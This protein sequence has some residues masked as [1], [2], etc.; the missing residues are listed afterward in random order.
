MKKTVAIIGYTGFVGSY[1][2]NH[3]QNEFENVYLFNSKNFQNINIK[4]I[5]YDIIYCCGISAKKWLANQNP[6]QDW[7]NMNQLLEVLKQTSCSKFIHIS[8]IDVY[9][10]KYLG[11]DENTIP[12]YLSSSEH[13]PYGIHRLHF[14]LELKKIYNENL[15]IVRLPALFGFGLRKNVL[16]D[17]ITNQI[18]KHDINSHDCLQW[19]NIEW[20]WED[21][22]FIEQ[23][24]I[25]IINLFTEPI[26]NYDIFGMNH[27]LSNKN[28]IKYD[29]KTI[30]SKFDNGYW[31]PYQMVLKSIQKYINTFQQNN[32]VLTSL[33]NS[34]AV[35][36]D[37]F[38]SE[39]TK[40]YNMQYKEIAPFQYFGPNF[41]ERPLDYFE[42]FKNDNIYSMQSL[43]YPSEINIFN[44][45][46]NCLCYM[47]KIID[48]SE[49]VG[50]KI[51]CFGGPK[52][53]FLRKSEDRELSNQFFSE[54]D[55]YIGDRDINICIEPNAHVYGCN[56]LVTSIETRSFIQ[57]LKSKNK[58][59]LMLDTGCMFLEDELSIDTF[60]NNIDILKHV[61]FSAPH[62]VSLI[63]FKN[64][65]NFCFFYNFLKSINYKGRITLEML[66]QPIH[67]IHL[68]IRFI[69]KDPIIAIIGAG[70]YGC[71]I[72]KR[73][74]QNG[75]NF[76]IF[77][78]NSIFSGASLFNQNRLHLG[79]HYARSHETRNLCRKYFHKFA[80][81]YSFCVKD[82][83]NNIYGIA[84]KSIVDYKTYC[85]I[86]DSDD[87]TY[88]T[89]NNNNFHITNC[90]GII[91]VHEKF[92]CGKTAKN[93][94]EKLLKNYFQI[95]NVDVDIIKKRKFDIIFDCTNNELGLIT[96]DHNGCDVK[97]E[98]TVSLIYKNTQNNSDVAFTIVDGPFI[99]LYPWIIE[100][101]LY[102]LT[103]VIHTPLDFYKYNI[104]NSNDDQ[105][106]EERN[107]IIKNIRYKMEL[108]ACY[109]IPSFHSRF[110]YV[111][112][113][114]SMKSKLQ[115]FSDSRHLITNI[116]GNIMSITCGKITGIYDA[117]EYVKK[118]ISA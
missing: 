50:A 12:M 77:D 48:I 65:I 51:L 15:Y 10:E 95:Q 72:A 60:L 59:G 24:N 110:K 18:S 27:N 37:S 66:N 29:F 75:S 22:K 62:L 56:F 4:N 23:N 64:D 36:K 32:L 112:Y 34:I 63:D 94:F 96:K 86:M 113:F 41:I 35:N 74:I 42:Q 105:T 14:E 104:L 101:N 68:S 54:L 38:Y 99:S 76:T 81:E 114:I 69:I 11:C 6:D 117:E 31:K 52:N 85:I 90:Q 103:H 108:D 118:W 47:K 46:E 26:Q 100:K 106:K 102:S 88:C 116:Q 115:S 17:Y 109:F 70:W 83:P 107:E 98:P 57:S 7:N 40:I 93:Y 5:N 71:H 33:S 25:K 79:F 45:Y 30:H 97:M 87:V 8:T 55:E 80:K 78:R 20:L 21:I 39:F 16:F 3:I 44:E 43:F 58:I 89:Q 28:T 53:R 111:N 9:S 67:K 82:I 19:Y 2:I 91:Q 92:I 13:H 84:Q 49:I 1:L 61:H 73:C